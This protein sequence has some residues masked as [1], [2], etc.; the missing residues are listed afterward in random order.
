MPCVCLLVFI[1]ICMYTDDVVAEFSLLV[2]K[3]VLLQNYFISQTPSLLDIVL[4][5][6]AIFRNGRQKGK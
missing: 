6:V 3:S 5:H 1:A 2:K 4:A